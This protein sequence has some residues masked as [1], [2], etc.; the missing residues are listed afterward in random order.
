MNLKR[1][2]QSLPYTRLQG[3]EI[4][5]YLRENALYENNYPTPPADTRCTSWYL[6]IQ[7]ET[8]R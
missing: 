4:T 3:L 1:M 6:I 5:D 7:I 8:G 2:F